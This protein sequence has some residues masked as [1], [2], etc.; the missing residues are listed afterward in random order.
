M[1][2]KLPWR[3]PKTE[4]KTW[5]P[6]QEGWL[7]TNWDWGWWQ[8]DRK[9]LTGGRNEAVEACVAAL[10]QTAAMCPVYHYETDERGEK[11]RLRG[12]KAERVLARPNEYTSSSQ[13][14]N[15]IIRSMYF[16]GNGYAVATRDGNRSIEKLYMVDP[17]STNG[18]IDPET[19]EVYY[20]VGTG[21][22]IYNPETDIVYP[23]RDVLNLKLNNSKNDPLKGET[24]LTAA[25]ASVA[26]NS[27]I[28]KHQASFFNNMSRPSGIISTDE[29]LTKEQMIQLRD[30][31]HKQTQQE[32]S[33]GIPILG[34][35]LKW[36]SMSLTSQDAQMVEAFQ[37]TVSNIAKV[38]R[39]PPAVIGDLTGATF[40]NSATMMQ[41]FLASGLGYLLKHVENDLN[42]LFGLP[43]NQ[44]LDF[45]TR[46]LLR[47]DFNAQIQT[48]G[49]GVLKGIYSPNEARAVL[50]MGPVEAGEEPR[51][52]QQVVPLS[53][54][55]QE[56]PAPEPVVV[57]E[58]QARAAI[59]KGMRNVRSS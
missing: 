53:A 59:M 1:K 25:M 36:Q 16:H 45:D 57:D 17:K 22:T 35:G 7:D 15:T 23:A 21:N 40:N 19:G 41:W 4:E 51:V 56:P 32:A 50:G 8:Q 9:P 18:T 42:N 31:V 12:S 14:F 55:D 52:Q 3:K 26:A 49:E 46:E 54:W 27:S 33:G 39:V 29:K 34:N 48:L 44:S 6:T 13:F 30:A 20:W 38:F 58:D 11:T 28:T 10:A 47:S 43:F 5:V 37:M 24:P 2:I